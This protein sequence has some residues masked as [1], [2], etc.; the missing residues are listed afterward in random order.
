MID[1]FGRHVFS[2][3]HHFEPNPPRPEPTNQDNQM[4]APTPEEKKISRHLRVDLTNDQMIEIGKELADATNE[5]KEIENEKSEVLS[6]FTARIKAASAAIAVLSNKLRSGY[7][8]KDVQCSVV[9]DRPI[10]GEKTI[11]RLDTGDIIETCSMTEEEK[12]RQLP[13]P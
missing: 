5:L 4:S 6:S 12:Q 10:A 1:C 9:Y 8:F 3:E 11:T 13:L 2:E 7:E